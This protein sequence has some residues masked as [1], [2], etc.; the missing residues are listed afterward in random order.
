MRDVI[1]FG[2]GWYLSQKREEL[3]R[4]YRIIAFLDNAANLNATDD[5]I[6]TY[7]PQEIFKLPD[8]KIIIMSVT[9]FIDM[10]HQ[11]IKESVPEERIDFGINY[12]PYYDS[13][14]ET[15]NTLNGRVLSQ[16]NK[17]VVKCD[18][19]NYAFDN[20]KEYKKIMNG[21]IRENLPFNLVQKLPLT[22]YSRRFGEE[23][24]TPV[25]RYYIDNFIECNRE[26]IRGSV[27]E[28]GDD[29]YIQRFG[30]SVTDSYVLHALGLGDNVIKGDLVSG[31]GIDTEFLD[32]FI[33]TQTIQMIYDFDSAVKNMCRSL[34]PGGNVLVTLHGISQLSLADYNRWGEYWRFTQKSTE[35]LF[36]KY[37]N[38]V[39]VS[40]YGNVKTVT[41]H[42]Y[43]LCRED[44]SSEDYSFNDEQYPLIVTVLATKH[45]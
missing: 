9:Y 12:S 25:D 17:L 26:K 23:R 39:T 34:K 2:R 21:L 32:C 33:C 20:I 36:N 35:I 5:H 45:L 14:E 15:L 8:V 3:E 24:G 13:A 28:I 29:S 22:P 27:M 11:L 7:L 37:F 42:L 18:K 10:Y 30:C 19:G 1:V 41:A 31:E 16:H 38:E 44:L 43:G 6:P 40:T 4:H